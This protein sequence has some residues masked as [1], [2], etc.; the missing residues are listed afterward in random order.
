MNQKVL[1]IICILS[2][3]AFALLTVL[4][5]VMLAMMLGGT[6][7]GGA[8]VGIIGGAGWPTFVFMLSKLTRSP[9]FTAWQAA[10]LLFLVS[11][12]V[13]LFTRKKGRE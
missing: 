1:K 5:I 10:L 3:A 2:G 13:R 4:L 6:V 12:L 9:A 7:A 8:S 11:L